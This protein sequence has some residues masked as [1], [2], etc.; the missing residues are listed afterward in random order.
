MRLAESV[1]VPEEDPPPLPPPLPQDEIRNRQKHEKIAKVD[2]V[3][4]INILLKF[5]LENYATNKLIFFVKS[6]G[7]ANKM[8]SC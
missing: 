6:D 2:F 4:R 8:P 1:P 3:N 7:N 5:Y